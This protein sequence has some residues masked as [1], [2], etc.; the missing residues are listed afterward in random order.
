[1]PYEF[2]A[3]TLHSNLY[4][5]GQPESYRQSECRFELMQHEPSESIITGLQTNG[6]TNSLLGQNLSVGWGPTVIT[7]V[8]SKYKTKRAESCQ[9]MVTLEALVHWVRHDM[10]RQDLLF[11]THW[12]LPQHNKI[13]LRCTFT[14]EVITCVLLTSQ[15]CSHILGCGSKA[16]TCT[17]Y[18][19]LW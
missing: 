3:R 5:R 13:L 7:S 1:M 2:D 19:Y 9:L 10:T 17:V 15:L 8:S 11:N 14:S 12:F 6:H 16:N 18:A 4:A